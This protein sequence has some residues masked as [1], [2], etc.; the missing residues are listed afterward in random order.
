MAGDLLVR[1]GSL[2]DGTGGPARSCDVRV[3]GGV[4][5]EVGQSLRGDTETVID[6]SGAVVAP[7]FIDT[8]THYDPSLWWDPL[9]D[10][11]AERPTAL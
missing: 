2:I 3:R 6:A 5:V 10:P 9:V 1:G 7:G 4:V 8:H 11:E